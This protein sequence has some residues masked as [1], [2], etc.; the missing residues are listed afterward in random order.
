MTTDL[1]WIILLQWTAPDDDPPRRFCL[2]RPAPGPTIVGMALAVGWIVLLQMST[3]VWAG[4]VLRC[5]LQMTM[6]V[7]HSGL[8]HGPYSG[9]RLVLLQIHLQRGPP[10]RFLLQVDDGPRQVMTHHEDSVWV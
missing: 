7:D 8:D 5:L 9:R 6:K 3:L 1:G 2:G 10:Q 4:L